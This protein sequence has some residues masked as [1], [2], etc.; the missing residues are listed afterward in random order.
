[1]REVWNT[2]Q[3]ESFLRRLPRRQMFRTVRIYQLLGILTFSG[4]LS[5]LWLSARLESLENSNSIFISTNQQRKELEETLVRDPLGKLLSPTLSKRQKPVG[6]KK[7]QANNSVSSPGTNHSSTASQSPPL[8]FPSLPPSMDYLGV[9]IDGGRHYFPPQ[10]LYQQLQH[11]HNLGYNYIHFRLT[12]DQNFVL[13]LTV[14]CEKIGGN[15]TVS[16]TAFVAR[17]DQEQKNLVFPDDTNRD[18]SLHSERSRSVVY[19]PEELSEFV[20]FAKTRYNITVI[21]EINLPGHAGAWGTNDCLQDLVVS[22]PTF[23]CSKGYGIPLNVSHPRLAKLVKIV[24]EN[25]VEIFDHPPFLHLGGDELDMSIPCLEEA[26][27]KD[28]SSWLSNVVPRFEKSVLQ[29]IVKGLGY[30][31]D[32]ILRWE[33]RHQQSRFGEIIHY[34]EKAPL[35]S[36]HMPFVISTTLYLDVLGGKDGYGYGD[37]QHA[38]NLVTHH[39]DN[40]PLAIVVGTFEL[41]VEFWEDRNVLGRL[42][43]IRMG[44]DAAVSDWNA[45]HVPAMKTPESPQTQKNKGSLQEFKQYTNEY[46]FKCNSIFSEY[47]SFSCKDAGLPRVNDITFQAKWKRVWKEWI[48]GVCGYVAIDHFR[49]N[50]SL[51]ISQC[52]SSLCFSIFLFP[53]LHSSY[54]HSFRGLL[55]DALFIS[56]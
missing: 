20:R 49:T 1:M 23:A 35:P 44:M 3:Y 52:S 29:P 19:Q 28:P 31:P 30:G 34:W 13:N 25:V 14:P 18:Q 6:R 15:R 4:V 9:M 2:P 12:D 40:L 8:S 54:L 21:P 7:R 41:G 48:S 37:F 10:W 32:Q 43:A 38:K 26:G 36:G 22:C 46:T 55:L 16:S 39:K 51:H 24:L 50:S 56:T 27:I 47:Q 33:T 5:I 53:L 42:L 45:P 17:R 11:I